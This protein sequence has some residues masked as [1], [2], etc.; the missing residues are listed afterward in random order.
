[1]SEPG[2]EQA[3]AAASGQDEQV[4]VSE[5][6]VLSALAAAK[7]SNSSSADQDGETMP[8]QES[9]SLWYDSPS[10]T[11]PVVWGESMTQVTSFNSIAQFWS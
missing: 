3:A 9:W 5:A 6:D 10:K 8:L 1:M 2:P 7:A 11:K 4:E